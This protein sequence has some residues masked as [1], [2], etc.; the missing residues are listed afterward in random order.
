MKRNFLIALAA[1]LVTTNGFAQAD[2]SESL[3]IAALEAL[4]SAPSETALPIVAKV[5]RGKHSDEVKERAL[6]ILSQINLPAAQDLLLDTARNSNGDLRYEAIR[7]IGIGGNADAMLGLRAIYKDGDQETREAVLEAYLIADDTAS[8]LD[9]ALNAASD[10]EFEEAVDK[11]G[12]MGAREEL[13]TLRGRGGNCEPLIDALGIADD[14]D[15]ILELA[16]DSSDK[17]CQLHAIEGLGRIG[18][19][20]AGDTL[21][22]I[23]RA[24]DDSD[25][26]ESA[27]HG[28]LIGD[29]GDGI[30]ALY[31]ESND[32]AEKRQLLEQLVI[33]GNDEVW[34]VIE[35]ALESE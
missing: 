14:Q 28:M 8:V 11:L 17:L 23:Y 25:V 19:A 1:I 30:L 35:S 7:M 26:K 12:A 16:R 33:T 31:R 27:L 29:Y 34:S 32:V 3:K 10:D 22:Q 20:A 18:G 5:L 4:M 13:R 2:D 9:I 15:A 21:L 6:F 24:S